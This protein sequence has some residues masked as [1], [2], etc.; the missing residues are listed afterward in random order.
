[1]QGLQS[2]GYTHLSKYGFVEKSEGKIQPEIKAEVQVLR[3]R[4]NAV[5]MSSDSFVSVPKRLGL[6]V[7]E[8]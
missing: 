1:M 3:P 5:L 6:R 8:I 2:K 4:R 7:V